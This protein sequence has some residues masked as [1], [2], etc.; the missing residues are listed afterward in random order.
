MAEF[1]I[2]V[3]DMVESFMAMTAVFRF[4]GPAQ[5][6]YIDW[7]EK[8]RLILAL[9]LPCPCNPIV[10]INIRSAIWAV[11]CG[12]IAVESVRLRVQRD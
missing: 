5:N 6:Q 2:Q 9:I 7:Y 12:N 3:A 8:H 1:E 4:D 11:S 10:E